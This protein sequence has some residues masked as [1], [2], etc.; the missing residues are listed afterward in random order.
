MVLDA[1]RRQLRWRRDQRL[2]DIRMRLP[3]VFLVAFACFACVLGASSAVQAASSSQVT[4]SKRAASLP[5][6]SYRWIE[7]PAQRAEEQDTHVRDARFRAELK[8]ALDKALLTKGYQPAKAGTHPDFI[9]G[10]RVGV[11]RIEETTVHDLPA[12]GGTPLAAFQC[13]GGDCSQMAVMGS[14]GEP[15][16]K[17]ESAKRSEGGLLVEVLEPGTIR[18]LWRALNRGTIKPGKI[19]PAR[20][21]KVAAETLKSLPAATAA[22]P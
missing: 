1:A 8:A 9:I 7:M 5:G 11:R 13:S 4:V 10:Y 20:L 17:L 21:D 6:T 16:M 3:R 15:V 2:P 19:T 22:Q 12:G 14:A 18:V